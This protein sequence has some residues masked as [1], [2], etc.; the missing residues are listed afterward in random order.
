MPAVGLPGSSEEE[1]VQQGE[2]G[3]GSLTHLTHQ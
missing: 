2:A 3:P 1:M